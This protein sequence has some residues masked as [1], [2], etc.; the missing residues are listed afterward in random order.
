ML[1]QNET[2]S[3]A[4]EIARNWQRKQEL[5][6]ATSPGGTNLG[7]TMIGF[8]LSCERAT[9]LTSLKIA[10]PV[11]ADE[12]KDSTDDDTEAQTSMERLLDPRDRTTKGH[13]AR[14]K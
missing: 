12:S 11:A 4:E 7:A 1:T 14:A 3:N 5:M 2:L 10:Q 13:T 6:A 9:S 8:A